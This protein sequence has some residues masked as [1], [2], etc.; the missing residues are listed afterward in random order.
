M[1][2]DRGRETVS[3]EGLSAIAESEGFVGAGEDIVV[4]DDGSASFEL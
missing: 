3:F 1:L 4:V 2:P